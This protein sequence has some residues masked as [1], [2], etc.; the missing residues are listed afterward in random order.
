[1]GH[2]LTCLCIQV[3]YIYL[4]TKYQKVFGIISNTKLLYNLSNFMSLMLYRSFSTSV[5]IPKSIFLWVSIYYKPHFIC[6]FGFLYIWLNSIF[7]WYIYQIRWII[8]RSSYFVPWEG[9]I[10]QI[11]S[12]F[13]S[14]VS[15]YFIFVRW[16]MLVNLFM[17]AVIA[18]FIMMPGGLYL[19]TF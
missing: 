12:H 13:G 19:N 10:R 18:V 8:E 7:I 14:V 6:L 2:Q 15:S 11:E 4:L 1:M 9:K 17:S 3:S 16:V 5:Q